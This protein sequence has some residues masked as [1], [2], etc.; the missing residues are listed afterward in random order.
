MQI[1]YRPIGTVHSPHTTTDGMPVQPSRAEGI[2]GTIEINQ[3]YAEGLADLDGFS[4]VVVIFHMHRAAPFK[5][6]VVPYLDTEVRGLFATRAPARPN[7]IGVSVIKL[8]AIEESTLT[9]EGVDMLDGT[10]V[11]DIKPYVPEFDPGTG[12]RCGWLDSVKDR[13]AHADS[14]FER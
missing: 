4:H 3:E 5:L 12:I 10:P 2:E 1:N 8:L 7:P 14:R 9:V 11:L 13:T 6:R